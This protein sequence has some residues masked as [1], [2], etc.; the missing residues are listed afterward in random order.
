MQERG[1][2]IP[3]RRRRAARPPPLLAGLQ[4][5]SPSRRPAGRRD[6]SP[7]PRRRRHTAGLRDPRGERH[8]AATY[9]RQPLAGLREGRTL[10][11]RAEG[12]WAR[13]QGPRPDRAGLGVRVAKE[14]VR[15][16]GLDHKLKSCIRHIMKRP[17]A[18]SD[19]FSV[20]VSCFAICLSASLSETGVQHKQKF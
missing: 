11:P 5:S 2:G 8:S 16:R 10:P 4:G 6:A 14:R 1:D 9:R 19:E 17:Y 12:L 15:R 3:P 13:P 18:F 20:S 7:H